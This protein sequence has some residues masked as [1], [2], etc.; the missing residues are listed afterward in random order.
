LLAVGL[1]TSFMTDSYQCCG[2]LAMSEL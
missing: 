1:L 2:A